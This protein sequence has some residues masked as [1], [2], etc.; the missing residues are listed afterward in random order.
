TWR[1]R[2]SETDEEPTMSTMTLASAITSMPTFGS[3]NSLDELDEI[4]ALR[5]PEVID[6]ARRAPFYAKHLIAHAP[7]HEQ[8]M[9]EKA[10][11][12]KAHPFGLLAV[13]LSAVA[14]YHESSGT[15]G[16]QISACYT[17]QDWEE[18]IDRR[19]RTMDLKPGDWVL[20]KTPYALLTGSHSMQR[21]ARRLGATVV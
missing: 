12:R 14:T 15:T 4:S 13:P 2:A 19:V 16:E 3:W 18:T 9:L 6:W 17:E 5:L 1:R 8:P 20:V 21:A 7:I 11:V 10:H